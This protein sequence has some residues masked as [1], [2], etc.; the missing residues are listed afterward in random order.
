MSF[1]VVTRLRLRDP[2]YLDEFVGSAFSVVDQANSSAGILAAEVLA[3]ANQTYWTRTVW[4][5]RDS[6]NTF[7]GAQPHLATMG[8]LSEW[9]DEATFVDWEQSGPALPDWQAAYARLIADG[10]VA[11]LTH[12]SEDHETRAFPPPVE[13]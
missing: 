5:D 13:S 10:Q 11:S 12:P 9:C 7:V 4:T 8:H 2:K 6:M 3:E 1:V